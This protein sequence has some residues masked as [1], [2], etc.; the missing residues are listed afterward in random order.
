MTLETHV[1]QAFEELTLDPPAFHGSVDDVLT[2]GRQARRRRRVRLTALSVPAVAGLSVVAVVGVTALA[3]SHHGGGGTS[4][5]QFASAV[6]HHSAKAS[7][8]GNP[9]SD[10]VRRAVAA[11]SPNGFTLD[12]PPI[13]RPVESEFG[14]DGTA[15]DGNGA[16]RVYVV[17]DPLVGS[18]TM[19][20]CNDP[21]FVAGGTCTS[22]VLS[23]GN[24][25]VLRGQNG[26]TYTQVMAVVIHPDGTGTTA[27]SDNGTFP[28]P[29][30]TRAA[31]TAKERHTGL[32]H[33]TRANPTYTVEQLGQVA[34]AA[35]QA[36]SQCLATHC[37]AG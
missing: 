10:A 8:A 5:V 19:A 37:N 24:T 17:V 16:G 18:L 14:I 23:N 4:T 21:D 13:A 30:S 3:G 1:R 33:V 26:T 20:P 27:E 36:A 31:V 9:A 2:A 7:T 28:H 29:P 34:V 12:I 25:L 35:D 22:T 32:E 15:N 11:A 6:T